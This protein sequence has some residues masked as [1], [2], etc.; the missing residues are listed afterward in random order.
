MVIVIWVTGHR[1]DS[2]RGASWNVVAEQF[3]VLVLNSWRSVVGL[4]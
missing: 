1:I 2:L 4:V 3:G